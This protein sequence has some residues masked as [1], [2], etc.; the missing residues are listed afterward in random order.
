MKRPQPGPPAAPTLSLT[1]KSF[2]SPLSPPPQPQSPGLLCCGHPG[3]WHQGQGALRAW[4]GPH[5]TAC[6]RAWAQNTRRFRTADAGRASRLSDVHGPDGPHTMSSSQC[7]TE[8]TGFHI[9]VLC[10]PRLPS[11]ICIFLP[12]ASPILGSWSGAR[13][14]MC[15]KPGGLTIPEKP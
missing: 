9:L 4:G 6:R 7:V 2:F 11:Q 13:T 5:G 8:P 3:G 1:A 10:L 12:D 14:G 15:L